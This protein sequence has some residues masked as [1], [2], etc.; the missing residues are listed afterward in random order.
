MCFPGD[1]FSPYR[2]N[3][4]KDLFLQNSSIFLLNLEGSHW[5]H[6]PSQLA[7]P[8]QSIWRTMWRAHAERNTLGCCCFFIVPYNFWPKWLG[9]NLM[10]DSPWLFGWILQREIYFISRGLLSDIPRE[11]AFSS[12]FFHLKHKTQILQMQRE[13]AHKARQIHRAIVFRHPCPCNS[14][15]RDYPIYYCV[16]K[17]EYLVNE[18][19]CVL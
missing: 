11:T 14:S 10:W 15:E 17:K 19:S 4:R 7:K 16:C 13:V 12:S 3:M 6:A 2:F 18:F 1:L 8:P 5:L 9:H